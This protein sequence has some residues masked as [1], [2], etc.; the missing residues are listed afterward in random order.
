MSV[1]RATARILGPMTENNYIGYNIKHLYYLT[2]IQARHM[3]THSFN[4]HAL[5]F[6]RILYT[7]TCCLLFGYLFIFLGSYDL[8]KND[9]VGRLYN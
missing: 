5:S 7:H 9:L 8:T 3:K 4:T 6:S 2:S 1:S